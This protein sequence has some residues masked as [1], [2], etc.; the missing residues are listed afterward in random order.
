[1]FHA[2]EFSAALITLSGVWLTAKKN[3]F[4]WLLGITGAIL[5]CFLCYHYRLYAES[6][7]QLCYAVLGFY[8]WLKW[9]MP[10]YGKS[11]FQIREMELK[12]FVL[13]ILFWMIGSI[14]VGIILKRFSDTDVPFSDAFMTIAG[15]ILTWQMAHRYI[16][17]WIGW[18]IIDLLNSLLFLYKSLYFTL[19]LYMLLAGIALNGYLIWKKELTKDQ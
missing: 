16:E 11:A 4:G 10:T 19:T 12:T 7:L 17:N 9:K 6:V 18:I 15:L 2:V 5:Y 13:S 14:S 1:M 3:I 8:G